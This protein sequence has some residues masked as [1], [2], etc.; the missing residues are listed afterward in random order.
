M[1]LTL[2]ELLQLYYVLSKAKLNAEVSIGVN[3]ELVNQI[4]VNIS[5]E[6][7]YRNNIRQ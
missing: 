1:K 7:D 4:L 6:I 5:N 2:T 3:I